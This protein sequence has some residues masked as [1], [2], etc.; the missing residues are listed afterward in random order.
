M[1]AAIAIP[2]HLHIALFINCKSFGDILKL[3]T[4][5]GFIHFYEQVS[6]KGICAKMHGGFFFF[7]GTGSRI[8][9]D[10]QILY[11]LLIFN[12]FSAAPILLARESV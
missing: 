12:E 11:R 8:Y 9:E 5:H 1:C 10:R 3:M 2:N 4:L 6:N 7:C